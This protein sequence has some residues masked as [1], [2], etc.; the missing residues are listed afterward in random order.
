MTYDSF[1]K[2]HFTK[3]LDIAS[4][5]PVSGVYFLI[6][7]KVVIYVGQSKDI[8]KRLNGH[9]DKFFNF[10][11]YQPC[12]PKHMIKTEDY[13]IRIL[14]PKYNI[15]YNNGKRINLSTISKYITF[16]V[17]NEMKVGTYFTGDELVKLVCEKSEKTPYSST[18]LKY[19]R[20]Y[21]KYNKSIICIDK[22]RS[23]YQI[24]KEI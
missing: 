4:I 24:G 3:R 1:I 2:D 15:N 18:V 12:I 23:L 11:L 10:V 5:Y 13:Y 21:R 9:K 20:Q 14:N 16:T 6:H 7:D 22:A 8:V 19:M 17:L